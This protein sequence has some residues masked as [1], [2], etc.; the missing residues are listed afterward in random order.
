MKSPL[1][2]FAIALLLTGCTG[3]PHSN[4]ETPLRSRS[5]SPAP[6]STEAAQSN[7]PTGKFDFYVL[8]L[9]WAPQFCASR[10][11]RDS[12]ECDPSR[13]YGFVVHGLWPQNDDGSYPQNCAGEQRVPRQFVEQL[14]PVMPSPGLIQHEWATHGTCSGLS[15][16]QY[17]DQLQQLFGQ[18]RIPAEY[19][20]PSQPIT[21]NPKDLEQK[22]AAVNN[23]PTDS[24]RVFCS[25]G[26]LAGI[27][28]CVG[29]DLQFRN[30]GSAVR[31]CRA[32]EVTLLPVP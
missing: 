21:A 26:D 4:P 22:F 9:S 5:D 2:L 13:H 11:S 30:C 16:Q 18:L 17:F 28:V 31:E 19:Q 15:P 10:D 25:R 27:D 20:H 8:A 24:F 23:A 14:L 32:H 29:K 12:N 1:A 6:A 3:K 7:R